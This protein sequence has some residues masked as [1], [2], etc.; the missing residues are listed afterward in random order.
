MNSGCPFFMITF[1][2]LNLE[3]Y[4]P[5][6]ISW[7]S[8]I[9]TLQMR[10]QVPSSLQTILLTKSNL[11]MNTEELKQSLIQQEM[12][13]ASFYLGLVVLCVIGMFTLYHYLKDASKAATELRQKNVE[14]SYIDRDTKEK[15]DSYDSLG[16]L[17]FLG[18]LVLALIAVWLTNYALTAWFNPELNAI[19]KL[20]EVIKHS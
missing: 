11:I 15:L 12:L 8:V 2:I 20:R 5:K 4:R 10:V 18:I 1:F 7:R 14:K 19:L 3:K 17:C 9:G 16:G 13:N 6:L